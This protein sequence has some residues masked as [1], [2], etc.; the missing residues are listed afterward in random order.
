MAHRRRQPENRKSQS[1]GMALAPS[2]RRE[3]RFKGSE[4]RSGDGPDADRAMD[5]L[6]SL[7]NMDAGKGQSK[8]SSD[9]LDGRRGPHHEGSLDR[10]RVKPLAPEERREVRPMKQV[11]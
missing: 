5:L 11:A 10:R 9:P 6:D 8:R 4:P 3:R 1:F 2:A 7:D